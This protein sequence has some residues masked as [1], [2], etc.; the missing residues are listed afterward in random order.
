MVFN[1]FYEEIRYKTRAEV[2]RAEKSTCLH[3]SMTWIVYDPFM[4]VI[5]FLTMCALLASCQGELKDSKASSSCSHNGVVYDC[6]T[7]VAANPASQAS[8]EEVVERRAISLDITMTATS[9]IDVDQ[10]NQRVVVLEDNKVA[11]SSES[12]FSEE[13]HSCAVSLRKDEIYD[14]GF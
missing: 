3:L 6:A 2:R 12:I 14:Y 13:I 4:K 5:L 9:R 11:T 8:V 7:G 10:E 1:E